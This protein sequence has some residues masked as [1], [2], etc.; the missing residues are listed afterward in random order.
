MN[1]LRR[2]AKR[3]DGR[4]FAWSDAQDAMYPRAG[5]TGSIYTLDGIEGIRATIDQRGRR[6]DSTKRYFPVRAVDAEF[7][8]CTEYRTLDEAKDS[9]EQAVYLR[10]LV[11]VPRL[12]GY[13]KEYEKRHPGIKRLAAKEKKQRKARRP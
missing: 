8:L 4:M 2:W 1:P 10:A 13:M 7:L 5:R 6:A 9:A 12:L 11:L 3:A